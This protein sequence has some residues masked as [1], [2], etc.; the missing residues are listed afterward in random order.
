MDH[1]GRNGAL[2]T[3]GD[4]LRLAREAGPVSLTEMA[5]FAGVS[6][7]HLSHVEKGRDRPSWDLISAY[8]DRFHTDGQ[9]WAA[10]VEAC[11]TSARRNRV[12]EDSGADHYPIPGDAS[13]FI[14]DVTIPDGLVMPPKFRFEK[15][16][17]I[18]NAGSTPWLGRW[19]AR[20]GA[21]MGHGVP[22]S[23]P[24]VRIADTAPGHGVDITVPLR[25]HLLAGTAQ[26]RWKMVDDGGREYFPDRYYQG[27]ILTIVVRENAPEPVVTRLYGAG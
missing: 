18:R 11:T 16:W 7:G 4:L 27:L 13:E 5:R 21:A 19:L 2:E 23:P 15:T 17:R 1:M 26:I 22:Q 8:E 3:L 20:D 24:R 14:A 9:L 12:P 6:K 25:A 10:Y